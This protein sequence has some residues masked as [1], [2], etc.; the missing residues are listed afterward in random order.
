MKLLTA[1]MLLGITTHTTMAVQDN[2]AVVSLTDLNPSTP[3][4]WK[5]V[6]HEPLHYPR[7]LALHEVAGCSVF[8][9]SV[10]RQGLTDSIRLVS[11]S[12]EAQ[13]SLPAQRLIETWQ[14]QPVK[15]VTPMAEIKRIRLDF[16]YS[17][18]SQHDAALLC[19]AQRE[20]A[21]L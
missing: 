18:L 7:S 19:R 8:D 2:Y 11:A 6:G 13:I 4:A 12:P 21:C 17:A 3:V 5:R 14:W 1:A 16:C 20:Q 15:T 9:V 10:S